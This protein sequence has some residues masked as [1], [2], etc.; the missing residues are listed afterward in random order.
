MGQ[1]TKPE[2]DERKASFPIAETEHFVKRSKE[3]AN[4]LEQTPKPKRDRFQE[5]ENV[6]RKIPEE[7]RKAIPRFFPFRHREIFQRGCPGVM[8]SI[9]GGCSRKG[10]RGRRDAFRLI[11][12]LICFAFHTTSIIIRNPSRRT[13]RDVVRLERSNRGSLDVGLELVGRPADVAIGPELIEGSRLHFVEEVV[14]KAGK[15][16]PI[17]GRD[18][19]LN[20]EA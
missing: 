15:R 9:P 6:A 20:P 10:W 7:M 14:A 2:K 16:S 18:R 17:V 1:I 11:W 12:P 4:S 19:I 5:I 13:G 3:M 8:N